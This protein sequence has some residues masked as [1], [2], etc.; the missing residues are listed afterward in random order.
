MRSRRRPRR[1]AASRLS[2]LWSP[3]SHGQKPTQGFCLHDPSKPLH[4]VQHARR[5]F[6]LF[7]LWCTVLRQIRQSMEIYSFLQRCSL[8][9]QSPGIS[10]GTPER[11]RGLLCFIDCRRQTIGSSILIS[12][13]NLVIGRLW[14][15]KNTRSTKTSVGF[16]FSLKSKWITRC[17]G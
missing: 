2:S 5:N 12:F 11:G 4:L 3:P 16:I 10:H 1:R 14:D 15:F 8:W 7:S 13:E 17:N 6:K 9:I